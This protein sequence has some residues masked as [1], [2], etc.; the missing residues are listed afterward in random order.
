VTFVAE[1]RCGWDV[2]YRSR[3]YETR[4]LAEGRARAWLA[5]NP[6]WTLAGEA[7]S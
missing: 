3:K 6:T 4:E 7:A 5:K 1:L 2:V